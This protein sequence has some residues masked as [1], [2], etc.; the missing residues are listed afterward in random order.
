MKQINYKVID[1]GT[2]YRKGVFRHFDN[3]ENRRNRA[4]RILQEHRDEVLHQFPVYPF[5]SHEFTRRL[6][7][8][9]SLADR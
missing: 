5:K 4:R 7:N 1:K 9:I 6:Q 3:F 2:Y 8:G